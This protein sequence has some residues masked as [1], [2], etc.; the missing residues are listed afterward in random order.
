MTRPLRL[1]LLA[2]LAFAAVAV[3]AHTASARATVWL[4]RPGVT[5]D[6]CNPSQKT[7]RYTPAAQPAGIEDVKAA[8]HP[9]VDCFYVYPTVS[10]QK[11]LVATRAID[12]E[13]RS[14]ALYQAARYSRVC[15]VFAPMYRQ[16]T[17]QALNQPTP[18]VTQHGFVGTAAYADVVQA[19]RTYLRRFNHGRGVVLIGHSQ[20]TLVLRKLIAKEID[21]KPSARRKLVSAVLLGGNVLVRKGSGVGGDFRHIAACRSDHQ[22]GC[23][24]AFSTFDGPVPANAIFGRTTA[25]RMAV[26][27]TNPAAL[28]GGSGLLDPVYP[29]Q[30]FA[31]GSTIAAAIA[32]VGVPVPQAP[33]PWVAAPGSY[34]AHCSSGSAHVLQV[35]PRAGAPTPKPVPDA[36]WGLHLTD[37]NIALGN[38]TTIVSAQARA[39]AGS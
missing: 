39:Y 22:L 5:P 34:S 30:P 35:T 25:K 15:R 6:P 29:T 37:A 17:L 27:C 20:G 28:A 36:T 14:I 3:P 8:K 33:A 26:L 10:D 18:G 38:L 32:L 31:P 12:P 7:A 1:L 16:Y 4:C 13:E 9:K 24:I 11:R 23:V 2:G 19:W 21:P